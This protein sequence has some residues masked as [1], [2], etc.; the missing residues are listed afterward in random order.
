MKMSKQRI[1]IS[2]TPGPIG[3]DVGDR[4]VAMAQTAPAEAGGKPTLL[5]AAWVPRSTDGP[6]TLAEARTVTQVIRRARFQGSEVVLNASD[7]EVFTS[8]LELP[9]KRAKIPLAQLARMEMARIHRQDA[10]EFTL[11]MWDVPAP[12]RSRKEGGQFMLAYGMM[13]KSV[14]QLVS[15]FDGTSL[16][17]ISCEPRLCGLV[18]VLEPTLSGRPG[19]FGVVAP[20]WQSTLVTLVQVD[21]EGQALPLYERRLEEAGLRRLASAVMDKTNVGLA[22]VWKVLAGGDERLLSRP[23]VRELLASVRAVQNEYIELVVS[24]AQR[25]FG[26][27]VPQYAS[28]TF[29]GVILTGEGVAVSGLAERLAASMAVEVRSLGL[30]EL[31][32]TARSGGPED[33]GLVFAAGAGLA[34]PWQQLVLM[35]RRAA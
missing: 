23:G 4:V 31:L 28:Q 25:S 7:S 29:Q 26:Y 30:G 33:A 2:G 20:G 24:E 27:A 35:G 10:R 16:H 19:L 5:A 12:D 15:A 22:G 32:N 13:S 8:V 6:L 34:N 18:R 9:A 1:S 14:E 11:G 21:V 3:I 17:V